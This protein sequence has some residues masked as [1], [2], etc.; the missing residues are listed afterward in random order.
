MTIHEHLAV[1]RLTEL[2]T[3]DEQQRFTRLGIDMD[4]LGRPLHPWRNQIPN[5]VDTKGE[6]WNWGPNYTV[7][8]IVITNDS[9][10][11][12][13]LIKRGDC[14][15]WALPGGFID[16][17][18]E[19]VDAARR[20]LSEET[21]LVLSPSGSDATVCYQG[22]VHDRRSTL[23]AWPETASVLIHTPNQ[24]ISAGDDAADAQ[25]IPLKN[26]RSLEGLY[27]S[28]ATLVDMAIRD[29]GSLSEQLEYYGE[30]SD[31]AQPKGGHMGYTRLVASLPTGKRVFIKRHD[32]HKFT[33]TARAEHSKHYLHKEHHVY[34]Q[35]AGVSPHV[36]QQVELR[37]DHT[38]LLEAYDPRDG[39]HWKAPTD[40]D[41]RRHYIEDI[42]GA[43]RSIEPATYESFPDVKPSYHTIV[44]EGWGDYPANRGRIIDK[45]TQS[46]VSGA[47]ELAENLDALYE[48][49]TS[50]PVPELTHFAHYDIR[51]SN[52]TWHPEHG[53]RIVD[54]SWA[55][56]APRGMDITNFLIDLTKA[57]HAIDEHLGDFNPDH[58]L[59]L[60]GFW[61]GHSTWPTP[62]SDQTV[63]EHQIGSAVAAY[64][65]LKRFSK[66]DQRVFARS[67][68]D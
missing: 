7:D 64:Q 15:Q 46:S 10:P 58:A 43:L 1:S 17:G 61:L 52:L 13:L 67:S 4:A 49:A 20:E 35:L 14:G 25:W 16:A 26:V 39:W 21:H 24:P 38:L 63:R 45:L 60:I 33:D 12:L 41:E 62:T 36:P 68:N 11:M 6:L 23:Y 19:P 37:D 32:A 66:E 47:S 40:I 28:H 50:L 18:E 51:Q 34:Q 42:V 5:L 27:G 59:M 22:P 54:W 31:I 65:L 29:N 53:V 57:G 8:P 30:S 3:E 56:H 9:T 48:Q 2:P 55:D 44:D